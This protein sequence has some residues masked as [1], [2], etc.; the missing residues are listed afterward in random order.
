M[1]KIV[2]NSSIK[3]YM[4]MQHI[5]KNALFS[6][7]YIREWDFEHWDFFLNVYKNSFQ[8]SEMIHY[9]VYMIACDHLP[10][11]VNYIYFPII[12]IKKYIKNTLC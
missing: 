9:I 12:Y 4:Y 3:Y 7:I 6:M 2:Q 10:I 5:K 1:I 11:Y 8:D